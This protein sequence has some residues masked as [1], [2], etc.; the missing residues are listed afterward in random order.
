MDGPIAAAIAEATEASDERSE[1]QLHLQGRERLDLR[2]MKLWSSPCWLTLYAYALQD[3]A[4]R[5]STISRRII[6]TSRAV[7]TFLLTVLQSHT[8]YVCLI[9]STEPLKVQF[10]AEPLAV[11]DVTSTSNLSYL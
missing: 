6:S 5:R 10:M 3:V 11:C 2:D 4:S 9:C 8:D 7:A 1:E